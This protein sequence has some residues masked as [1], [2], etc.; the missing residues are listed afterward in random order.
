VLDVSMPSAGRATLI[1]QPQHRR[2]VAHLLYGPP[3]QRGKCLV[4]ED[5][6]ALRDVPVAVRVP[7]KIRRGYTVPGKK[8]LKLRTVG[9][10]ARVTVGEFSCH[11]AVVFEY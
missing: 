6:I 7:E 11:T 1:H 9:G 8:P 5:L 10:Q 3:M 2:Y 4:I